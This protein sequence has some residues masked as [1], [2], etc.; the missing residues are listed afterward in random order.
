MC[1]HILYLVLKAALLIVWKHA[2]LNDLHLK[3]ATALY[4]ECIY[5]VPSQS[6]C[7]IL[8]LFSISEKCSTLNTTND[9]VEEIKFAC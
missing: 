8:M 3:D 5:R 7:F 4:C 6:D 9:I 2:I 1:V